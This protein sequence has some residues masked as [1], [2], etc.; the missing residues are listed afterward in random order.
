MYVRKV[1][2]PI[3]Q[4]YIHGEEYTIDMFV[5]KDQRLLVIM[6][7]KRLEIKAGINVKGIVQMNEENTSR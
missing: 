2:D 3:I 6:P 4:E 1:P 5:D 7:R